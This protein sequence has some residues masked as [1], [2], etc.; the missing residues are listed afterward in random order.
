MLVNL[1]WTG[2]HAHYLQMGGY[3][4]QCLPEEKE[5]IPSRFG[6]PTTTEYA[7]IG[8]DIW[9][10]PLSFESMKSGV[11]NGL[12]DI[13]FIPRDEILDKNGRD[14]LSKIIAMVQ[15]IWFIVQIAARVRQ[16]LAVT[17]LELTTAALASLNI[18]MY[19][20]WWEKPADVLCPTRITSKSLEQRIRQWMDKIPQ[21]PPT[22]PVS[23]PCNSSPYPSDSEQGA[24]RH[25]DF[26]ISHIKDANGIQTH[27][28]TTQIGSMEKVSAAFQFWH[29]WA[30]PLWW[31][32]TL[33]LWPILI[34]GNQVRERFLR[35]EKPN[36]G[37]SLRERVRKF[38]K[39][40][41]WCI[42]TVPWAIFYHLLLAST[43]F[44][45]MLITGSG[46][47]VL[48]GLDPDFSNGKMSKAERIGFTML[49]ELDTIFF[50]EN[51]RS[52][53]FLC[54][55]AFSGA[56]FG[57]IHCLAWNFTFPSR[58][59]QVL[60]RTSSSTLLG[61]CI[62]ITIAALAYV[63]V[64]IRHSTYHAVPHTHTM[65]DSRIAMM[66]CRIFVL[67]F[68]LSRLFLLVLSVVQL[69]DLPPS[70]FDR[71]KWLEFFPHI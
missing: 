34:I 57:M 32:I 71:V 48:A 52:A 19:L 43:Y 40:I 42:V 59:E 16:N 47:R 50:C 10:L 6:R 22:L 54:L 58:F 17:E 24:E 67:C 13:P 61:L 38:P 3:R 70:A 8:R 37:R 2:V 20:S 7:G 15:L 1:F 55:S 51:V 4:L 5:F 25:S 27:N 23:V 44:P 56:I 31:A 36:T 46:E 26:R 14:G 28:S 35:N 66:V 63:V 12:I 45:I 21:T 60:W 68:T 11:N 30:E 49:R 62:C 41:G 64:E 33:P 39:D 9:E 65:Y 69:R 29:D 53:L 18:A